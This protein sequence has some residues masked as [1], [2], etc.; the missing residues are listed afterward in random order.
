MANF[1]E[2]MLSMSGNVSSHEMFNFVQQEHDEKEMIAALAHTLGDITH[3]IPACII[4]VTLNNR[5]VQDPIISLALNVSG[6][7]LKKQDII[8]VGLNILR[9]QSDALPQQLHQ[10][11]YNERIAPLMIALLNI[12][13][14]SENNQFIL[15][16]LEIL[17]AFYPHFRT[18]FDLDAP[19][20]QLSLE[21][22]RR[23]G[24]ERAKLFS[25]LLPPGSIPHQ[26]RH[27][28]VSGRETFFQRPGSRL[29][30]I[31]PRMTAAMNQY[32]WQAEFCALGSN[33]FIVNMRKIIEMCQQQKPDI[34]FLDDDMQLEVTD[35]RAEMIRIIRQEVPNIKIVGTLLDSWERANKLAE[36]MIHLDLIWDLTLPSLPLWKEPQFSKKILCMPGLFSW[37]IDTLNK[38]LITKMLFHGSVTAFNW[39][40]AFWFSA[41]EHLKIPIRKTLT[42]HFVDDNLSPIES[43][44]HYMAG[45]AE[46]TCCL[47][48]TMRPD[49]NKTC[50][51]TNRT[52]ETIFSGSLLVQEKTSDM[53]Y[54]FVAGEHYLEFSSLAELS[55]ITQ[56]ITENKEEVEEIRRCGNAFARTNYNDNTLIGYLENKLY[57]SH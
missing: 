37:D 34:L 47:N 30:D 27:V 13:I 3:A 43:Y 38:P 29:M 49:Y 15:Q 36:N 7:F 28:I 14:K 32:G 39:H 17:K 57:S 45:L 18:V 6:I 24:R 51:V 31:G 42:T 44:K 52:Y 26:K 2:T 16:T 46:A 56:L 12:G 48:F 55:A 4:A 41:I 25:Y 8:Q 23:A 20:P 1:L 35:M 40:R 50:V 10:K 11:I 5:G 22:M 33:S 54:F 19:V 21:K 9:M 53:D